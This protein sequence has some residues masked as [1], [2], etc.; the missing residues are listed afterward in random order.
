MDLLK[1]DHSDVSA[2]AA[3][4]LGKLAEHGKGFILLGSECA[5]MGL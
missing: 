3:N 2:A 5:D 4:A 1:N